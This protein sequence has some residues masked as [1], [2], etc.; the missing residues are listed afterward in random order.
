MLRKPDI[1]VSG[2]EFV[3]DAYY[4]E[5]SMD[6]FCDIDWDEDKF[7]SY[8]GVDFVIRDSDELIAVFMLNGEK[9]AGYV[10][11]DRFMNGVQ[12]GTIS[13][14]DE[15]RGGA[16]KKLYNCIVME[17]GLLYSGDNQTA[18][19]R[20]GWNSLFKSGE[21]NV[22]AVDS[23]GMKRYEVESMEVKELGLVD[24]KLS[25]YGDKRFLLCIEKK[26]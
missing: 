25:L 6:H 22:Y 12:I 7:V 2:K 23:I 3:R 4:K 1:E 26:S 9:P 8:N 20:G 17:F 19:A 5:K 15:Y 14:I 13:V 24:D 11:L 21:F 18:R 10:G 16:M